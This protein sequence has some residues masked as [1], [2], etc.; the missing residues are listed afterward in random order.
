MAPGVIALLA[1]PLIAVRT[2]SDPSPWLHLKVGKFLAEGDRFTHPDPWAPFAA[3][4]Y[5]PTQW[6]PSVITAALFDRWGLIAVAWTRAAGIIALFALLMFFLSRVCRPWIATALAGGAVVASWPW[7]TERPQLLGFV[8]L[9]PVLAAWWQTAHDQQARWWLV[10]MTWVAA[11]CHGVWA[12]GLVIGGLVIV[13]LLVGRTL[14]V[15]AFATL[16]GLFVACLA[17]AS[18]TPIGPR[19]LFTPFTVGAN[20]KEFVLEWM[21]SSAR[22]PAVALALVML[23]AAWALWMTGRRRPPAYQLLLFA[24]AVSFTLTMQRTVPIGAFLAVFLLGDALDHYSQGRCTHAH[25]DGAAGQ[26]RRRVVGGCRP[27]GESHRHSGGEQSRTASDRCA[28]RAGPA[29]GLAAARSARRRL[30]RSDG[31]AHVHRPSA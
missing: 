20:G 7:L 21:P 13:G 17:V 29:A 27:P 12:L 23:G 4:E 19:L 15:R 3:N 31:L 26:G 18:L 2:V 14:T 11:S 10:P 9:V 24:S 25:T 6:L 30:R 22:T 16:A 28:D 1:L 5:I 8:L